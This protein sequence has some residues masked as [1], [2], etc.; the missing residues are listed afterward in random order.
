MPSIPIP[1]PAAVAAPVPHD[2]VAGLLSAYGHGWLTLA[3]GS[4]AFGG[5]LMG[6]AAV[7]LLAIARMRITPSR[8]VSPRVAR[9]ITSGWREV[10]EA[11]W[12]ARKTLPRC[13]ASAPNA[14]SAQPPARGTKR[15]SRSSDRPGWNG[16][17]PLLVDDTGIA[18]RFERGESAKFGRLAGLVLTAAAVTA[19][20]LVTASPAHADLAGFWIHRDNGQ[21][22]LCLQ[23]SS[24][25]EGA[26]VMQVTC[27]QA[28]PDQRWEALNVNSST[29]TFQVL[30]LNSQLCLDARGGATDG[31]PVQV[32]PC[33]SI[34]N[35]RWD[36]GSDFVHLRSRVSGTSSHCL[37]APLDTWASNVALQLYECNNTD[38]QF[39]GW[40]NGIIR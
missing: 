36:S 26:A 16:M 8:S 22:Q 40:S 1:P 20:G 34:S 24:P 7:T 2:H 10:W 27:D 28:N 15:S 12:S 31:T 25:Q 37:D 33:N 32:W 4:L 29:N 30:N 18:R 17:E 13:K 11:H 23:P 19:G 21:V 35:E 9:R 5:L 39:W 6:V 14:V 38:A 3:T